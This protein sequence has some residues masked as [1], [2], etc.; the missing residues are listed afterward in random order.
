MILGS[1]Q[2]SYLAWIPFFERMRKSDIFVYLDDVEFS[3][4]SF[5]NRNRIKS[6]QGDLLLT[7]PVLYKGNSKELICNMPINNSMNWAE[8]HWRSIE[9]NYSKSKYFKDLGPILYSQ[10]YSKKWDKL[11]DLNIA[12]IE[13]IKDFVGLDVKCVRSSDLK[14]PEQENEKLIK[15]CKILSAD[16]FIVKPGTDSYHPPQIFN[17]NGIEFEY[18][19]YTPVQYTQIYGDFIGNLS[20]LDY[21]MNCGA[22]S[23]TK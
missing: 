3:K 6:N 18:F 2:P 7:L 12:I 19:N 13:I 17:D 15:I 4:N 20:M 8:K 1:V 11:G 23:F 14:V 5:H 16:K 10:I 21:A 9:V 22:G